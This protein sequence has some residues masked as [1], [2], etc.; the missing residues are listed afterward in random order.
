MIIDLPGQGQAGGADVHNFNIKN[1]T[2][3]CEDTRGVNNHQKGQAKER[4]REKE[5]GAVS[6]A[7][8]P[9]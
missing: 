9:I 3:I 1:L 8:H 7:H 5:R 6:R 2:G 4:D